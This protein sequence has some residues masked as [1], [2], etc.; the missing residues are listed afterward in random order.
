MKR[1][2]F[3]SDNENGTGGWM[4]TLFILD[5]VETRGESEKFAPNNSLRGL[6]GKKTWFVKHWD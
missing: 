2:K 6:G 5:F 3:S 1:E 4:S